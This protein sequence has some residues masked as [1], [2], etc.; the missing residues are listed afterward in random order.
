MDQREYLYNINQINVFF[1]VIFK[2]ALNGTY[3][4]Q[5]Y[6]DCSIANVGEKLKL[7]SRQL[8]G[9]LSKSQKSSNIDNPESQPSYV[10]KPS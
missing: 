1:Y 5:S 3:L 8:Q 2:K 7:D 9:I 4:N 10:Q 6:Q